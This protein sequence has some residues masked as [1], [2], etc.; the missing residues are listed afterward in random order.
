MRTVQIRFWDIETGNRL[1]DL[2]GAEVSGSGL[3]CISRDGE[4]VALAESS[5]LSLLDA[6]T[7][8]SVRKVEL[9]S[10]W[11]RRPV[12]SA[13]GAL[14]ALPDQNAVALFQVST[15]RRLFHGPHTP[16]GRLACAAWSPAGDRIFTGHL[17][18]IVRMWDAKTGELIWRGFSSSSA[19]SGAT[20]F[21]PANV[22]F[23]RD[24]AIVFASGRQD[25][26]SRVEKGVVVLYDAATGGTLREVFQ[27]NVRSAALTPDGRMVVLA[28]SHGALRDTSFV[29]VEAATGRTRWITRHEHEQIGLAQLAG[30]QFQANSPWFAAAL[31]DGNVIRFN[32]LTGHE[33]RRFLAEWR[34]PDQIKAEIRMVPG[35]RTAT[36]SAD[37]GTLASSR[38]K[39]AC[40]WDVASGSIAPKD[41]ASTP[42]WLL[43]RNFCRRTH[44]GNVG[45]GEFLRRRLQRDPAV[46]P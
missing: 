33:E 14:L 24:G 39:W 46:Q 3:A 32:G 9:A 13:S 4:Y 35:F 41:L 40:V 44:A 10:A 27:N 16:V 6:A 25:Y 43:A 36:F 28:T 34:T 23:S 38:G 15:F 45:I 12:F 8:R 7:G 19:F 31:G 18:G 1:R 22:G 21:Q 26:T 11:G 17:D 20:G 5:Q 29:G 42:K 30:M 37:G 2:N